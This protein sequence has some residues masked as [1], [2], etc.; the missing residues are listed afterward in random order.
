MGNRENGHDSLV[1]GHSLGYFP[2]EKSMFFC[3]CTAQ[4]S[5]CMHVHTMHNLLE[6]SE[7]LLILRKVTNN[8]V[9]ECQ[10][11]CFG[12]LEF[13][14]LQNKYNFLFLLFPSFKYHSFKYHS[15]IK[16]YSRAMCVGKCVAFIY[17][18]LHVCKK[19][20]KLWNKYIWLLLI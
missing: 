14:Q 6:Y 20:N 13:I 10:N 1:L 12:L 15:N 18:Q 8:A 19:N 17:L 16:S 4:M 5:S 2:Q 7:D 11:R 3:V 9:K